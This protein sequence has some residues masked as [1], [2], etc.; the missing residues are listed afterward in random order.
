MNTAAPRICAAGE[1]PIRTGGW[2]S[3]L[4]QEAAYVLAH[5]EQP[6]D[7]ATTVEWLAYLGEGGGLLAHGVRS[8]HFKAEGRRTPTAAAALAAWHTATRLPDGWR[9]AV[10][11]AEAIRDLLTEEAEHQT[12][13]R[14]QREETGGQ[15]QEQEQERGQEQE[16]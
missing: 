1:D 10:A 3:R 11:L 16:Q 7:S 2:E 12:R 5:A 15:E 14:A 9:K 13:R 8:S 4:A 6:P